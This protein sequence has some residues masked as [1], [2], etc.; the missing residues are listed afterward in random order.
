MLVKQIHVPKEQLS[1]EI[2]RFH[3]GI[4]Y[5]VTLPSHVKGIASEPKHLEASTGRSRYN[6]EPPHCHF[7]AILLSCVDS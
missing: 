7:K 4:M 6:L 3:P 2:V 1:Y 5:N